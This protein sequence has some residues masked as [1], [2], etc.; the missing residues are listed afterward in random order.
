MGNFNLFDDVLRHDPEAFEYV[1][2][3]KM[4]HEWISDLF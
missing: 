2:P 1:T 3:G 4:V